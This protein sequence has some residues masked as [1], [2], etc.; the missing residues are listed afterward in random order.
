MVIYK[1]YLS[2]IDT[3]LI[4]VKKDAEVLTVQAQHGFLT[5]WYRCQENMPTIVKRKISIRGTGQIFD[6]TTCKYIAT[7]QMDN[8]VWHIFDEGDI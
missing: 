7:V 2:L 1:L 4:D 6:E 3:Q 8:L 5:L